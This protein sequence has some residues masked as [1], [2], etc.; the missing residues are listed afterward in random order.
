MCDEPDIECFLVD[1]VAC[2]SPPP[3]L[4]R[5]NPRRYETGRLRGFRQRVTSGRLAERLDNRKASRDRAYE[6]VALL[7]HPLSLSL[8]TPR[9]PRYVNP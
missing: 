8:V 4:A 6:T 3:T 7:A 2:R 1:P 5:P 9:G